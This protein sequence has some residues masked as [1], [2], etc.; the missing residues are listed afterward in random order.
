M[1]FS[2]ILFF[3]FLLDRENES[4]STSTYILDLFNINFQ[5]CK[6]PKNTKRMIISF[7][8]YHTY[9]I[10]IVYLLLWNI[11]EIKQYSKLKVNIRYHRILPNRNEYYMENVNSCLYVPIHIYIQKQNKKSKT[12]TL[13]SLFI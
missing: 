3:F 11:Y 1:T 6:V 12:L 13:H 7:F 10:L 2:R 9:L 5:Q 8:M 4:I